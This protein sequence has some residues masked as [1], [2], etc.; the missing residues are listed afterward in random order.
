MYYNYG[1]Q[2]LDSHLKELLMI[3]FGKSVNPDDNTKEKV[4]WRKRFALLPVIVS[5]DENGIAKKV[6]W[7]WYEVREYFVTGGQNIFACH[8]E[9]EYRIPGISFSHV[10]SG[11]TAAESM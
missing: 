3:I 7:G 1:F 6:L 9:R 11:P 10:I 5:I 2:C 8:W 4:K